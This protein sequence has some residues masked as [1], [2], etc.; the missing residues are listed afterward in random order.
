[1]ARKQAV[2]RRADGEDS[3]RKKM[4]NGKIYYD[5]SLVTGRLHSNTNVKSSNC[6][7]KIRYNKR[8]VFE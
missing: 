7:G 6:I 4:I 1:M 8:I 2:S 5:I 3:I